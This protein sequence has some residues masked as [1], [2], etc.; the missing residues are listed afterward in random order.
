MKFELIT[1]RWGEEYVGGAELHHQRLARELID[2]GHE[3]TI[4]T[5][6][7]GAIEPFCHW[8]VRWSLHGGTD[9]ES[10]IPVR[11]LSMKPRPDWLLAL[12]AKRVQRRIEKEA[13]LWIRRA[14]GAFL[15]AMDP[16]PGAHLLTGWHHHELEGT[17]VRRW[18]S[19]RAFVAVRTPPGIGGKLFVGGILP[20]P[21]TLSIFI[22]NK[23]VSTTRLTK[24]RVLVT[25][26][27]EEDFHG[28]VELRFRRGWRPLRD[29]RTLTIYTDSVVFQ[30]DEG[31]NHPADPYRD[32]RALGRTLGADWEDMLLTV[33]ME[34]PRSYGRLMDLLRGPFLP[35]GSITSAPPPGT[36]R[37][38]CNMPWATVTP[39]GPNDLVMALWH[40]DDD[41]YAWSHWIDA[42]RGCRFV[43]ANSPYTAGETFPR[44]GIR[45]HF[46]G[47]PIWQP[48]EEING[49]IKESLR[50]EIDLEEGEVLLLTICRKSPEKGYETVARVVE[51]LRREGTRIRF[52]GI[53]PDGDRRPFEYD[54]CVWLGKRSWEE[55]QAAYSLC[56]L[57]V[58][59]SESE[60]FGMVI[61]EAWHHGRPVIANRTCGP[62]A[63][64]IDEGVD[65]LLAGTVEEL[66]TS[67]RQLVDNPDLRERLGEAGKRKAQREYTKGAAAARL[68]K[69][70]EAEGMMEPTGE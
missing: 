27:I 13:P 62:V 45:S 44:L 22:D 24:G 36:I 65:G 10:D 7:G 61:P 57:F 11:R 5:S 32:F 15:E 6:D 4:T 28:I 17:E 50:R 67:I 55:L 31:N 16:A 1:Y 47:P 41:Y 52:A 26:P 23:P 33:A 18:A 20:R 43:L 35:N 51:A 25:V 9:T 34:R 21:N 8:G 29:F 37:I 59:N 2:A 69:A 63:S 48:E 54:G 3:V 53:G 64:L 40:V 46:V 58:L 49:G 66:S 12:A 68:L 42:L 60:S 19:Q 70:L 14:G 56:D 39:A 38:F 30:D